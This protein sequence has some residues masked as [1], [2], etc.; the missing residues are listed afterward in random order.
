[1]Y[2]KTLLKW[3]NIWMG[4]AM[5]WMVYYHSGIVVENSILSFIKNSGYGGVDIFLFA[6][7]VGCY[8]SLDKNNDFL[9][10]IKRRIGRIIPIYWLFLVIWCF[11]KILTTD[12]TLSAI[13]GNFLCVQLFTGLGNNFNW[14]ISAMWLLYF[15]APFFYSI[16]KVYHHVIQ[17]VGILILLCVFTIPFWTSN[18]YIIMVTRIPIFFIGMIFAK[19][20]KED[21]YINRLQ[22]IG[23]FILMCIG[24][25][26][27][28]TFV[29]IIRRGLWSYGLYW[30][31]FILIVPGLCVFISSIVEKIILTKLGKWSCKLFSILGTYSFEIFLIHALIYD[32]YR[33]LFIAVDEKYNSNK[34]W[35]VVILILIP[36]CWI[37]VRLNTLISNIG[38]KNFK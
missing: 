8:Y 17:Y 18:D 32:I 15:L 10:F 7:G 29:E 11:Y 4:I 37:F 28:Y 33:T 14:Y 12:I 1:M 19:L 23:L 22:V 34:W 36:F 38:K 27:L 35:Y 30:Y 31:P 13:V 3:R 20:A 2:V 21:F 5:L 25:I 9:Q 16:T 24:I 26:I 6:S